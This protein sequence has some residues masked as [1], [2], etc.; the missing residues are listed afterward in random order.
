M[1]MMNSLHS[2]SEARRNS[3]AF[4]LLHPKIQKWIWKKNWTELRD[5][6]EAAITDILGGNGDLIISAATASG[7]TEAAYLPICSKLMEGSCEK[8]F[9]VLSVSPLKALIN[10]QYERLC[11]FCEELEIPVH[12]W[13][14]DVSQGK[15]RQ[16]LKSPEGLLLIT[17]ESLEAMFALRGSQIQRLFGQ[18]EFI[19]V[20]ELHAFIGSVRGKQLQSL[21]GRIEIQTRRR[22]PRVALSA[23]LG[24]MSKAAQFLREEDSEGVQLLISDDGKQE[25]KILLKAYKESSANSPETRAQQPSSMEKIADSLYRRLRGSNNLIFANS[26]DRVEYFAD[27]LR[28]KSEKKLVP[29]EFFP[30]HGSLSKSLREEV[31]KALKDGSKPRSVVCTNTLELGIDIGAVKSIAQI[32]SAPSV[33]SLRQRLGRSGRGRGEPCILRQFI[34]ESELTEHSSISDQIRERLVQGIAMIELLL[35][36]WYEPPIVGALHLSTLIQQILSVCSQYGGILPKD[37]WML[38]C[39]NGAFNGVDQN[40][41]MSLLRKLGIE[42]LLEQ[43]DDGTLMLGRVGERIV[44]HFSFFAAFS[45]PEE[46]RIQAGSRILGRLPISRPLIPG[47][48]LIFAGKRWKILSVESEAKLVLVSP[49]KAGKLPA[50][51]SRYGLEIHDEVRMEMLRIYHDESIPPYLDSVA[52]ELLQEGRRNFRRMDLCTKRILTDGEN[53]LLFPWVGDIP[54]NTL[55]MLLKLRKLATLSVGCFIEVENASVEAVRKALLSLRTE[56]RTLKPPY[57]AAMVENKKTDKY[58]WYLQEELLNENYSSR[59]IDLPGAKRAICVLNG[60]K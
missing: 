36:G 37:A 1:R 60:K 55:T 22:V 28:R 45:T 8:G 40:M 6:Q 2:A 46:Y 27:M 29:N 4:S 34:V 31:E 12:R 49:A 38:L 25:L 51:D 47:S 11:D 57:L 53:V 32:G 52:V 21:L 13:H 35:K 7:K 5:I 42:E 14:G 30:H 59:N 3:E 18:L 54:L 17:P 19:V 43:S 50:F 24:D 10:D 41:M 58:D 20:D 15:K 56:L 9:K 48:Y 44:S 26:R 23:T 16:A 39:E 33:A